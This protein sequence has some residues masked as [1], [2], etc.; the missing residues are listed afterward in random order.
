MGWQDYMG[1]ISIAK[2]VEKAG[3]STEPVQVI[4][5]LE[6]GIK[7]ASFKGPEVF[8]RDWDHQ[9]I[10]NV[11]VVRAKEKWADKYDAL[12]LVAEY[13]NADAPADFLNGKKE[14]MGCNMP[15]L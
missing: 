9:L 5:A 14:E 10:Q 3:G 7:F 6:S 4:K 1:V 8:Y 12:E 2:A 11:F 15:K 13:P